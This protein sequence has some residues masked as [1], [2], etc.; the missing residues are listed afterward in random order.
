MAWAICSA[1][2]F[3][4]ASSASGTYLGIRDIEIGDVDG[5]SEPELFVIY[6]V[7]ETTD[8]QRLNTRLQVQHGYVLPWHATGV[9]IEKSAYARKNLVMSVSESAAPTVF[10]TMVLV[11]LDPR[12]GSE[13]WRSPSLR[14]DIR[15][16]GVHFL[17]IEGDGNL[18][19]SIA[20]GSGAYLTR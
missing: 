1:F 18:R 7:A 5:D 12:S 2:C 4:S 13:V 8:V 9:V 14:G 20:S 6:G 3:H 15:K 17:D 11:T 10:G 19:I 16:D